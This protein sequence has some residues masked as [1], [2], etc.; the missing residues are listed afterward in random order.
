VEIIDVRSGTQF[1]NRYD[2]SQHQANLPGVDGVSA[3]FTHV[4][5]MTLYS[6]RALVVDHFD[7]PRLRVVLSASQRASKHFLAGLRLVS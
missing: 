1:Q 5:Q 2:R 6:F 7:N 4:A 3:P